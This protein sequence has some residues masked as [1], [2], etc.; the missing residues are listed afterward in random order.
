MADSKYE[1]IAA[2]LRKQIESGKLEPGDQLQTETELGEH[3][4][5]SRNTVREAIK[6]LATLGLVET[7]AGQGT[8]VTKKIEPFVTVLTVYSKVPGG[9]G[10][11]Q[12]QEKKEPARSSLKVGTEKATA[13]VADHLKLPEGSHVISRRETRAIDETPWTLETSYYPGEFVEMGATKLIY[14]DDIGQGA[15]QYL[16]TTLGRRESGYTDLITVRAPDLDEAEIFELPKDGRVD[17]FEIFR[18][19]FDQ[20]DTPMRLTVTVCPTDRNHFSVYVKI[21]K[22]AASDNS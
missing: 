4:D 14:P 13:I 19:A 17:V 8:F 1:R 7:R 21:P 6:R 3:Y 22:P 9:A 5:A 18:T 11:K 10:V 20:N 12:F 16:E 15:V 2:D